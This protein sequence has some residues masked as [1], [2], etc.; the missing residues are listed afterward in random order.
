MWLIPYVKEYVRKRQ[1]LLNGKSHSF[2]FMTATGMAFNSSTFASYLS[3]IFEQEVNILAGTTKLRHA[4]VTH[5]YSLPEAENL[6]LR[7]SLAE[8]MRHSLKHQQKTY[9]DILR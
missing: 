6:R 3:V 4:L 9:C 5:V 1:D 7:E 2:M 8:L